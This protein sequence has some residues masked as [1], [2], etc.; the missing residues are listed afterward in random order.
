MREPTVEGPCDAAL[1]RE[2]KAD[3]QSFGALFD[4][5]F[6][7]V[8]RFASHQCGRDAARAEDVA[9]ETF[10]RAFRALPQYEERGR[11]FLAWLYRIALNVIRDWAR[12]QPTAVAKE[13]PVAREETGPSPLLELVHRLPDLQ[14]QVVILKVGGGHTAREIGDR[15]ALTPPVAQ[16][17]VHDYNRH[18]RLARESM[19]EN[20]RFGFLLR[21]RSNEGFHTLRPLLRPFRLM[22]PPLL[23]RPEQGLVPAPLLL[24]GSSREPRGTM[25]SLGKWLIVE[26]DGWL[27][28]ID[29]ASMEV[30][31]TLKLGDSKGGGR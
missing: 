8:Y 19:P 11:P 12:R 20:P 25:R 17:I 16:Q 10:L 30:L 26:K 15:G 5:H 1:V 7:A 22:D 23:F 24:P 28:K 31:E 18:L 2:A 9:Q 29:P 14:R 13:E 6:D 3:P 4:R 27:Y 21:D